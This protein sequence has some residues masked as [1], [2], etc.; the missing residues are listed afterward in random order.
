MSK[1][2]K[3]VWIDDEDREQHARNLEKQIGVRC[4]F[5]NVKPKMADYLSLIDESKPDLILIDHNLNMIGTGNIKKGS[6]V[7]QLIRETHPNFAIACITAQTMPIDALQRSS[8]EAIFSLDDI[9]NNYETMLSIAKSFK[10]LN[11]KGPTNVT[12][13]MVLL[14]VPKEDR[15]K[16]EHVLPNE[17][18]ENF[19]D[20]ALFQNISNWVRTILIERPGFLYNR[21]WAATFLGLKE[22]G[23]KKVENIFEPAK[24]KGLFAD[25]SKERW[26]KSSLMEILSR[27]VKTIGLPW[28]KGR[29]LPGINP[30]NHSKDYYSDY[31]EDLP[32]IVAYL[33]DSSNKQYPMKLKYT[34]PHPKFDKL[35]YFEEIRMMKAD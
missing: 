1:K 15:I 30:Q 10:K 25:K 29:A 22:T 21:I 16:I 13:L 19:E 11:T 18:K 3:F 2:L 31:K 8:Y 17:I 5:L 20:K 12:E 26:W 4:I 24:Y 32:E 35:L 34:V 27:N 28:E 33:D 7:A 9:E 23:F 6:T 14:K